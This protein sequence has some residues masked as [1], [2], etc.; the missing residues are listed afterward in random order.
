VAAGRSVDRDP[1]SW[2]AG[3]DELLGRSA[4]RFGRVEPRRRTKA[5]VV[6]LLSRPV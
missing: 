4:G 3:L 1:A 6:G 5:F 2:Q